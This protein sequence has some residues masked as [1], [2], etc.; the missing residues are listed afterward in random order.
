MVGMLKVKFITITAVSAVSSTALD[1]L[2][3]VSAVSSTGLDKLC[4]RGSQS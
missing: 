4:D 2:C 1:K 3:E